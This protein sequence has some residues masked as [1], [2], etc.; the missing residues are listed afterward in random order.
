MK[1][2]YAGEMQFKRYSDTS[3]QGQTVTFTVPSREE[4]EPFIGLEGK[5]FQSV[6]VLIGDDE[7]PADPPAAQKPGEGRDRP[8]RGPLC[9]WVAIRCSEPAF[10][11]W[12]ETAHPGLWLEQ[13]TNLGDAE[14]AA[15]EI[16]RDLCQ[17]VS[18]RDLDTD[19]EAA[20]RLHARVR[21]PY[22]AWLKANPK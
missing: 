5:R 20:A 1:H 10:A 8:F 16:V 15:A 13:F 12:L 11:A 19:E 17:V 6:F 7:M 3:T 14:E 4:L 22:A 9:S 2:T 18:R 21:K